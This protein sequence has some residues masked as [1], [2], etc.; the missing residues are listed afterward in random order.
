MKYSYENL[1]PVDENGFYGEFGG[2]FVPDVLKENIMELETAFRRY[3]KDEQFQN[4][5]EQLLHD[6]VGRPTPLYRA[7]GLSKKYCAEIYLKREDLNHTGAHKINNA[8]G[9]G[10][11]ARRMGKRRI[12]AETGAGQHGVAAATVA[13]LLGLECTVYMGAED[14][15]RQ[16]SN[17]MRM[18]MLGAR[19]VPAGDCNSTLSSAVDAALNAWI[20]A[21]EAFYM[22]G[23]AVGPHPYPEIVAR[24]Q[25]VISFEIKKQLKEMTG[26]ET[27]D[28]VIACIGGGSNA[29]G[30][31]YHYI[32]DAE[33][34]LVAVEAGGRGVESGET[35]SS[36]T[37][38]S[39][40]VLHGSRTKVLVDG[41]GNVCEAYSISAGL[42]Y[43][44][45]GPLQAAL[46]DSGR[47][48]VVVV[49]DDE[50]LRAARLIAVSEGII[51]ALES[52][53][54][55]AALEKMKFNKGDVVVVN[56]SGRGDKD[57]ATYMEMI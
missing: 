3:I 10:L 34:R 37:A 2:A 17:V 42:D 24:F 22:I 4:D 52:A 23:S 15:R 8:I 38:G 46:A 47:S 36:L 55:L 49:N 25:S 26:R 53:H 32:P 13:A 27:P 45:I 33:V 18:K 19:V 14:I 20:S 29:A 28:Y 16:Q 12:I 9:L 51:P 56:L 6:Y 35:A 11:L 7:S 31:F 1:L 5:F 21:P 30:A 43:P 40:S 54:A 57:M 48:S 39:T 41:E 50:A 44:G